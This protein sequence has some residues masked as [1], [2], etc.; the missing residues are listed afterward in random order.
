[1][2]NRKLKRRETILALCGIG[3]AVAALI[4]FLVVDI[5]KARPSI[6]EADAVAQA[7]YTAT[8]ESLCMNFIAKNAQCEVTWEADEDAPRGELLDYNILSSPSLFSDG[9]VALVYSSGPA[10]NTMPQLEGLTLE[11]A[12][13]AAYEAGATITT[14]G[15]VADSTVGQGLV[16][17]SSIDAGVTIPYGQEVGIVIS[18]GETLTPNWIGRSKKDVTQAAAS[19]GIAITFEEVASEKTPG[20]VITQSVKPGELL[21]G[22]TVTL[23]I[24][25]P[26]VTKVLSL[27]DVVGS[28]KEAAIAK[29]EELG[30]TN[31]V[32]VETT[33]G[34]VTS[35]QISQMVPAPSTPQD[36]GDL[37]VLIHSSPE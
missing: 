4:G 28:S 35:S 25:A 12:K 18:G 7:D 29:L 33:T 20:V 2:K 23:A 17:S 27:P 22:R 5:S 19:L 6:S 14:V 11:E 16:A 10:E 34:K 21:E 13:K 32:V 31:V 26:E 37:I 8:N 24:A 36:A 30:F 15:E 3:L 9:H 1:M